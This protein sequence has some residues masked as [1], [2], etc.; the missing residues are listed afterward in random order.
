MKECRRCKEVKALIEFHK[1]ANGNQG[2][3]AYCKP[4]NNE[5]AA[6]RYQKN[7]DFVYGY[8]LWKGC[9]E[10]GYDLNPVALDLAHKDREDKSCLK[11]GSAINYYWSRPRLKQEM[12]K[13][14]VLCA[15]CHRIETY[16]EGGVGTNYNRKKEDTNV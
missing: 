3:A 6:D 1:S 16:N 5:I 12:R 4:C 13:T 14:R 9:E 2:V 11:N 8:K 10:C 15:N 7:R